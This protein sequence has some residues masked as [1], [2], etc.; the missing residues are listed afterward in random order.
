MLKQEEFEKRYKEVNES[1]K[2]KLIFKIGDSAGFFSEFNNMIVALL[3]C[4]EN[5][6]QFILTDRGANFAN[7]SNT[8][9]EEYF[10]PFCKINRDKIHRHL[11]SRSGKLPKISYLWCKF[12]I[13]FYKK[14]KGVKFFTQDVFNQVFPA[15]FDKEICIPEL[16]VEGGTFDAI[17]PFAQMV[18]NFNPKTKERFENLIKDI[19]LPSRYAA[20]QTRRGDKFELEKQVSPETQCYMEVL[21]QKS[22]VKDILLLSDDYCDVEHLI[23]NYPEYN[24]YTFCTPDEKGYSNGDFQMLGKEEKDERMVKLLATVDAMTRAE[25]AIGTRIAN[26]GFFLKMIMDKDKFYFV[27]SFYKKD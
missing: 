13:W 8:P 22:D 21:K 4:M 20:F 3:F 11:N 25:V 1:Y 7:W 26:P 15:Y 17:K 27:E 6:V 23:S 5:K 2:D 18:W 16:N 14:T 19:K 12:K 9:Y 10:I 24:F